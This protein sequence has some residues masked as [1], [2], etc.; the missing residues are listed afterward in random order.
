MPTLTC[1]TLDTVTSL[2]TAVSEVSPPHLDVSRVSGLLG[3][4]A[5]NLGRRDRLVEIS[6]NVTTTTT[7]HR[8][9]LSLDSEIIHCGGT[10]FYQIITI[11]LL[12]VVASYRFIN[13]CTACAKCHL[14]FA[15]FLDNLLSGRI[16]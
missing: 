11:N 14:G 8:R 12:P 16:F 10:T 4:Y 2:R 3:A 5:I 7:R 9:S 13:V 1:L 6:L 15:L